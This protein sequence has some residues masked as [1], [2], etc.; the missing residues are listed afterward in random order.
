MEQE[1]AATTAVA[2]G[3]VAPADDGASPPPEPEPAPPTPPLQPQAQP[4]PPGSARR[5]PSNRGAKKR[6]AVLESR[7]VSSSSS[8][9]SSVL[10]PPSPLASDRG[11]MDQTTGTALLTFRSHDGGAYSPIRH[12]HMLRPGGDAIALPRSDI[13]ALSDIHRL[14][15]LE[16]SHAASVGMSLA[17]GGTTLQSLPSAGSPRGVVG[18]EGHQTCGSLA[19][20]RVA[21]RTRSLTDEEAGGGTGRPSTVTTL[22]EDGQQG[23]LASHSFSS[24]LS[25]SHCRRRL[26]QATVS[27]ASST[28]GGGGS[29]GREGEGRFSSGVYVLG[30]TGGA[31]GELIEQEEVGDG[32]EGAA[33]RVGSGL[34][35][36]QSA[37]RLPSQ[38][39]PSKGPMKEQ[40]LAPNDAAGSEATTTGEGGGGPAQR[41]RKLLRLNLE[42]APE[43]SGQESTPLGSS[44]A[45]SSHPPSHVPTTGN[46]TTS[47]SSCYQSCCRSQHSSVGPA[48]PGG[49]AGDGLTILQTSDGDVVRYENVRRRDGRITSHIKVGLFV[50]C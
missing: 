6:A 44:G 25:S 4:S 14:A 15:L 41:I 43:A 5:Q 13:S 47:T 34:Q 18:D 37:R 32:A 30:S 42:E 31:T 21:P 29:G 28:G 11:F 36:Q 24:S 2:D 23:S 35:Q 17:L 7:G 22:G 10:P 46:S 38:Q 3:P 16:G 1:E 50:W 26:K 48:H 9:A 27:W 12:S 20:W 19:S 40:L 39:Q 49:G 8:S 33:A 45:S